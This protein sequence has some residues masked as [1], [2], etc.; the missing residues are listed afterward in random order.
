MIGVYI[1]FPFCA[2]KCS[3]CNFASGVFSRELRK[4]YTRALKKELLAAK[5]PS[6]P[7]TLYIGGGT[8]SLLEP[9]ELETILSALPQREWR[10]ATMEAAPGTL[11]PERVRGWKRLG[12]NR[13]SLGVQSFVPEVARAAGRRHTPEVVCEE[14]GL[15]RA[16]GIVRF[17]VDLIA[18]LARQ[19]EASW[20]ED[21]TWAERV[22]AKHVS[23]Y[24]L[25]VDDESRLGAELRE[26]GS[27]YGAET[28]PDDD[29]IASF[30]EEAVETLRAHGVER[31]EISNFAAPGEESAHNLKYWSLR[32]YLGFGADAHSF[33]GRR[34]WGNV[35]S[36]AEYADRIEAGQSIRVDEETV[37][38]A[39]KLEDFL[40]TGLRR[41]EGLLLSA[42][43]RAALAEPLARLGQRGWLRVSAAG[44]VRL[45]DDGILFSN[46][47]FGELTA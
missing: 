27:R 35:S 36:P 9:E 29:R 19:S 46:E 43:R 37:E 15:L 24:M 47:V 2:Q 25:E 40:L 41:R 34:R 33:D 13:V 39:R 32:P 30:Y 11:T 31:Y 20:R 45:T 10:E 28:V 4:R 22:E 5:Y 14:I 23:V 18:G 3:Y 42:A 8:P 12:I 21:F 44:R 7:E 6:A 16:E 38:G 17:N 26:G 1:S